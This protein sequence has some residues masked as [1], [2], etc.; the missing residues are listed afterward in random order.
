MTEPVA[1]QRF[2]CDVCRAEAT[3]AGN[4]LPDGW[5]PMGNASDLYVCSL[6]CSQRR[7]DPDPTE[8]LRTRRRRRM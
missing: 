1:E 6:V 2:V 7:R 3:A 4:E 8:S 5:M